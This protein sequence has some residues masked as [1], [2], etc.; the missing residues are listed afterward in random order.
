MQEW[1]STSGHT[2]QLLLQARTVY[3]HFRV[4]MLAQRCLL[5][6]TVCG[7]PV[8]DLKAAQ[9]WGKTAK[10]RSSIPK[11]RFVVMQ[12]LLFK[13]LGCQ[14]LLKV[15]H[16]PMA[17]VAYPS[18]LVF[19]MGSDRS[20]PAATFSLAAVDRLITSIAMWIRTSSTQVATVR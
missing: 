6:T 17:A 10:Q 18:A 8:G 14:G 12:L 20:V 1:Q 7:S 15:E 13:R 16:A 9:C 3:R 4:R 19:S 5:P 11:F 2:V